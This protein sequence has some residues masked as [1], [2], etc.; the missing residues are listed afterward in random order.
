MLN[1]KYLTKPDLKRS[2][3]SLLISGILMKD[4]FARLVVVKRG[5]T[6]FWEFELFENL[7]NVIRYVIVID[8]Y[9]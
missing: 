6:C 5:F 7:K 8:M 9:M 1:L 3:D 4:V 2:L